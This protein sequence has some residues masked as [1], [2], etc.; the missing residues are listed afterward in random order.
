MVPLK[1]IEIFN[2]ITIFQPS[3]KSLN[4]YKSFILKFMNFFCPFTVSTDN[5]NV[6]YFLTGLSSQKRIKKSIT[7]N[8]LS[9]VIF[10]TYGP[11]P[12]S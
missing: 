5:I 2:K 3:N 6:Q 4:K 10:D 8:S 9:D 7:Q 11:R 12:T 1:S